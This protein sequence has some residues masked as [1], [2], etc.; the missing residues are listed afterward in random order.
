[1][2]EKTWYKS[3]GVQGGIGG[4]GLGAFMLFQVMPKLMTGEPLGPEDSQTV[5]EA[6]G[7]IV[8]GI[9]AVYG[10]WTAKTA[11]KLTVAFLLVLSL[12][13]EACA[14]TRDFTVEYAYEDID[15]VTKATL[16]AGGTKICEHTGNALTFSCMGPIK[17]GTHS[18]TLTVSDSFGNES[19]PSDPV[20]A[21]VL[22]K[23]PTVIKFEVK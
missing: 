20:V 10:R 6:I 1:M 7:A 8:A 21:T 14:A 13:G 11:I 18:F 9:M 5:V 3:F 16:Y 17:P 22:M 12:S 23:K 19:G 15:V 2:R 4:I